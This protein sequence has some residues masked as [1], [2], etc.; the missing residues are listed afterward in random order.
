MKKF[1]LNS[2]LAS[3]LSL[4]V[5][6]SGSVFASEER[7]STP[8]LPEEPVTT[9]LTRQNAQVFETPRTGTPV[10]E[11]ENEEESPLT[12]Q[13]AQV[14][15]MPRTA[16]PV[17]EKEE[18]KECPLKR[19]NA[20]VFDMPRMATPVLEKE[21][22]K[23]SSLE[24]TES[25]DLKVEVFLANYGEDLNSLLEEIKN[26]KTDKNFPKTVEEFIN[27]VFSKNLKSFM[28][29]L[30]S[31]CSKLEEENRKSELKTLQS[32]GFMIEELIK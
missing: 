3:V 14:F 23:E 20:Q 25:V 11:N 24:R 22:E 2:V 30:K 31:E 9:A 12:R 4:G 29:D 27:L 8:K 19:Q 10:L 7:A 17:L 21:E 15:D 13:N 16:T 32:L 18:E 26:I 6:C 5:V 1:K 28:N